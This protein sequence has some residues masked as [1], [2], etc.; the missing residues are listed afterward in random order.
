MIA[1]TCE[2]QYSTSVAVVGSVLFYAAW[3][4]YVAS[5]C[6]MLICFMYLL[7]A[8]ALHMW[9][10]CQHI[11][12][13]SMLCACAG[14]GFSLCFCC[15]GGSLRPRWHSCRYLPVILQVSRSSEMLQV[16]IC[17][18]FNGCHTCTPSPHRMSIWTR[19]KVMRGAW[20]ALNALQARRES[21]ACHQS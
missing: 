17:L 3:H 4:A 9:Q 21:S 5:I 1:S 15:L 12:C 11:A 20:Q 18:L 7:C 16:T 2:S 10:T 19:A 6:C 14:Q 8:V 13:I